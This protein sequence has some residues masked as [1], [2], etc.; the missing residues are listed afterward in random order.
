M[1]KP[2]I[3]VT[4]LID[5][6]LVLLIIFMVISPLKPSAFKTKVPHE[7]QT[8]GDTNIHTLIVSVGSDL[9][10]TLNKEANLGSVDD[11]SRLTDRLKD[12][13]EQRKTNL[14]RTQNETPDKG[15]DSPDGIERTVFI[16]APQNLPYGQVA[17]V[18]D[19]VKFAGAAPISLQID[20]LE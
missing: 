19:A 7:P 6:L 4:P 20:R 8:Q 10:L 11:A 17:R 14:D 13:F 16:K 15:F 5:V 18:I 12:V 9:S 3:N 1:N 2:A